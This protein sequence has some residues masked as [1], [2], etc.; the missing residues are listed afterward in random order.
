MAVGDF[1]ISGKIVAITGAGTGML[2]N[3]YV[4]PV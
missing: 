4:E 1:P 2:H 3:V